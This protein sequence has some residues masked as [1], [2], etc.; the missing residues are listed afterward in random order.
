MDFLLTRT[1]PKLCIARLILIISLAAPA[2]AGNL[3][4]NQPVLRPNDLLRQ[5]VANEKL[6]TNDGY[7]AWMD[8]LQKPRGSATKLM[9]STPQGILARTVQINDR[10]LTPDERKQDDDRIN[11]L[12]DPAKM[13]DKAAKQHDDQQHIERMLVALP[14]A[15]KCEYSAASHD[16]RNLHLDC[17]PNPQFSAPNYESQ[18]LQ[19][20]KTVILI[21]REDNRITHIEGTLFKEVSF[22]WGFIGKL[23]R[24]GR[25]EIAQSRMAGKHWSIQCMK[26]NF[27][28]RIAF[29]KPLHIEET[30][31]SWD[32]RSVPGMSVAQALDYLRNSPTKPAH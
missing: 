28:G 24:G 27:D 14:D 7:F 11:R 17:S 19:G 25:I 13:K 12:L 32:Y 1:H 22:G 8:R 21:D 18:V 4:T 31:T 6:T 23:N 29:L 26:L 30:E 15:F 20:M 16:D 9:V 3:S 5:A 10:P 2:L